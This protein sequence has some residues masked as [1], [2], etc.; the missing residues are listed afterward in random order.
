M[1]GMS[2]GVSEGVSEGRR[3]A[4][5]GDA[6]PDAAMRVPTGEVKDRPSIWTVRGSLGVRLYLAIAFG[7]FMLWL[8]VWWAVT[9]AGLVDPLFLPSPQSVA[10]RMVTWATQEDLLNDINISVFRVMA[11][12]LLSAVMAVPLGLLIGAFRPVRAFFEPLME[13]ARYLPAV[14]FVPLVLLWGGIG[15]GSKILLIWIGT[16]F[17]MVL[18]ISEDVSRVPLTQIEAARTLG[19]TNGEILRLVLLRSSMPAMLDTLRITLGFAWTYLVVAELV[20]ADSGL[21][22]AILRAQR[23]LQTDRI[24]VGI[25]VIGLIGLVTD[26]ALRLVHRK[27]FHW[28][29]P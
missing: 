15:E 25:I 9:Q 17:Q 22:Y 8:A 29:K 21:G 13:F 11:G 27:L 2:E 5:A 6:A 4:V 14:A 10:V 1:G 19:A 7:S 24:F 12:F 3:D 16:F 20:A 23:Y 28:A 18:M 26:Q